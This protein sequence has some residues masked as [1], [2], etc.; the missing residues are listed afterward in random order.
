M[1]SLYWVLTW[2][3]HRKCAHCYDDRFRPYV[4][5]A[6]TDIVAEVN[7]VILTRHLPDQGMAF[8]L[9]KLSNIELRLSHGGNEK[10]QLG[11]LVGAF[12]CLR[13]KMSGWRGC[14]ILGGCWQG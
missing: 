12:V 3:C 6:L 14:R 4:R 10:L 11:A 5:G 8:I 13:E 7:K 9:D 2:A 1:Q